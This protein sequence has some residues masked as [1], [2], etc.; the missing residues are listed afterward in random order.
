MFNLK[1]LR[2]IT[3]ILVYILFLHEALCIPQIM[4]LILAIFLDLKNKHFYQNFTP[5]NYL[6]T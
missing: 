1:G 3:S 5:K 4:I 2:G 6:Y